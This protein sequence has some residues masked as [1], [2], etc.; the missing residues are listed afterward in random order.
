MGWKLAHLFRTLLD[1]QN[2]QAQW[3]APHAVLK[4]YIVPGDLK[5]FPGLHG[6][7]MHVVH[8]HAN[9]QKNH[10]YKIKINKI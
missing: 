5:P 1:F 8:A 2:I 10:T 4:P 7:S 3:L 6:H 9:K